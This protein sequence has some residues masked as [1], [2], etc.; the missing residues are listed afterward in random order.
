MGQRIFSGGDFHRL[1]RHLVN[2]VF[3]IMSVTGTWF[4]VQAVLFDNHIS[5]STKAYAVIPRDVVPLGRFLPDAV[6][7]H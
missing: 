1:S 4:L 2:L 7:A 5:I 3:A 6:A